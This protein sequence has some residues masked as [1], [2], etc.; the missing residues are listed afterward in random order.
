MVNSVDR[1]DSCQNLSK[2]MAAIADPGGPPTAIKQAGEAQVDLDQLTVFKLKRLLVHFPFFS[3]F[4]HFFPFF[5]FSTLV[6]G[7]NKSTNHWP[8]EL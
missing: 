7:V 3:I 5:P 8:Q 2:V 6:V 4:F 1:L